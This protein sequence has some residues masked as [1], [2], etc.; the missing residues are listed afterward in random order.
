LPSKTNNKTSEVNKIKFK[1]YRNGLL[2]YRLDIIQ[3]IIKSIIK[4]I[5]KI[6]KDIRVQYKTNLNAFK[7]KNKN[8]YHVSYFSNLLGTFKDHFNKIGNINPKTIDLSNENK[9]VELNNLIKLMLNYFTTTPK[10]ITKKNKI[11]IEFIL[12]NLL[13]QLFFLFNIDLKNKNANKQN[14]NIE[15]FYN[16]ILETKKV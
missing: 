4:I 10:E 9:K 8:L 6:Q 14:F 11:K 13:T 5:I 2:L 1:L 16:I 12:Q 7:L 15:K 3:K